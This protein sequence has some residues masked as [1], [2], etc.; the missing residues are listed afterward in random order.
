MNTDPKKRK[1]FQRK[2]WLYQL[3]CTQFLVWIWRWYR[4]LLCN[5]TSLNVS[6]V[7]HVIAVLTP[8]HILKKIKIFTSDNSNR[9]W[10]NLLWTEAVPLHWAGMDLI[11]VSSVSHCCFKNFSLNQSLIS[12]LGKVVC[13]AQAIIMICIPS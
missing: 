7:W 13:A 9:S 12:H 6:T 3:A 8:K 5:P 11:P 10:K 2:V 1:K 4:L